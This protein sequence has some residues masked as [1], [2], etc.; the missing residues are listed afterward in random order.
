LANPY[1]LALLVAA[2][3]LFALAVATVRH[4]RERAGR[5]F[6]GFLVGTGL[7]SLADA[8]RYA[9]PTAE[10]VLLWNRV[11]YLGIVAIPP[12]LLL[13]VVAYTGRDRWFRARYL[14]ALAAVSAAA[15][16]AVLTNP[17]HGL[18]FEVA[19]LSPGTPPPVLQER[20]GPAWYTW[21]VYSY[22]VVVPATYL[23]AREF[24]FG[25]PSK[26]HR[27]Q[28][29]MVLAGILVAA[30]VNGLFI[31]DVVAF[32]PAPFVFSVTGL[33]FGVAMFRYE[34][35][36][37]P[38]ARDTVVRNMDSGVVVV[39][40]D[41]RVVDV[42]ERARSMFDFEEGDAPGTPV[43]EALADYPAVRER[44]TAERSEEP[45]AIR[46]D[47]ERR[48][49]DV[50]V[51]DLSDAL[52]ADIGRVAVLT[53]ITRRV[54]QQRR[55][56][57]RTRELERANDRLDEFAS[58]V[59]HDLR[60]P[61]AVVTGRAE[62]ARES[63]DPDPH[64]AAVEEAAGRMEAMIDDFLALA[65]QGR[66]VGE[67]EPVRLDELAERTWPFD[68][69]TSARL[70]CETSATVQ[71]DPGRLAE[72]LGN[73]F[74]NCVEHGSMDSRSTDGD[75]VEHG[76]TGSRPEADDGGEHA[77]PNDRARTGERIDHSATSS[78]ARTGDGRER[79]STGSR[80]E[81]D[82]GGERAV[83]TTGEASTPRD[84]R[85]HVRLGDLEDGFFVEDDG[86][87]IPETDRDRVFEAGY[88]TDP[89]G[90]GVGLKVVQDVVEAHGWQIEVTEGRD[91]GARFEVTGV[92]VE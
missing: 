38:I 64:L 75:G 48:H 86:P 28:T 11:G 82:D 68:A 1:T 85:V 62:L 58:V 9:A 6:F 4:R 15:Y 22:V 2:A 87:G 39:D 3:V 5:A 55:L 65:R 40:A 47:G 88:S 66:T 76:S 43:G 78:R 73:L 37:L 71:A 56:E 83:V 27:G 70:S 54:D 14:A 36:T 45:V 21:A 89:N 29:G 33:C 12:T 69:S 42:N 17:L 19:S 59:S 74:R 23:M 49:Y 79:S 41:G 44:L 51:S 18:W 77:A 90:T 57:E 31:F 13:F 30:V 81:A 53:D 25:N 7:W 20:W 60:N 52:G 72:A 46:V 67:T 63:D 24:L 50:D 16:L 26:T 84:G 34:L 61:L 10:A 92:R 91:G 8:M 80:P 32:D 35:L